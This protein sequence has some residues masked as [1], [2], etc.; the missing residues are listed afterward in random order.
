LIGEAPDSFR[1][2]RPQKI[3]DD[4]VTSFPGLVKDLKNSMLDWGDFAPNPYLPMTPAVRRKKEQGGRRM[5]PLSL[6]LIWSGEVGMN[7]KR[8]SK[9][10]IRG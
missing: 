3:T 1:R 2:I 8:T 5:L 9:G 7:Y 4:L 6:I 10:K